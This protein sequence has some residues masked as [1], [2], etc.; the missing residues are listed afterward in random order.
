MAL[1][2]SA[3]VIGLKSSNSASLTLSFKAP[4]L[5]INPTPLL[6]Q[7]FHELKMAESVVSAEPDEP[8][9]PIYGTSI[10]LPASGSYRYTV[11][12]LGTE[13]YSNIRPLPAAK[14][15]EGLSAGYDQ[16]IYA[17]YQPKPLVQAAEIAVLRDF[18]ILQLSFSPLSWDSATG[19]LEVIR[20]FELDIE[21]T[22]ERTAS[23][24]EEYSTYSPAFRKIYEANLLNFGD[25]RHLNLDNGY[26]RILLLHSSSV[27]ATTLVIINTFVKWKVQKGYEVM[28][29][30]TQTAGSSNT[31][32]KNYIQQQYN[33][34]NT[35]P[36][37]VIIVGD[38]PQ[39]PTFKETLSGYNGDGDYPYTYLAGDDQLGD[40]FIGRVSANNANQLS[41]VLRK[42]YL[43]ERDLDISGENGNWMDKILLVGDQSSSGISCI[44]NCKH[45]KNMAE[46]AYDGYSFTEV[47]SSPFASAINDGINSGVAFFS[48]RGWLGMSGW[49]PGNALNNG[50]KLPHVVTLTCST[51]NFDGSGEGTTEALIR[52]G[53]DAA[54][55][56]AVT[57]IGMAT[58]GTHTMFNNVL[59]SGI[60]AGIFSYGMRSMGEALLNGKLFLRQ[61][62]GASHTN[63]TNYM[64]HWANLMGD[65]T[66]EVF[67]GKPKA[68]VI[69]SPTQVTEGSSL[70]SL[71]VTDQSGAPVPFVS[72]TAYN[73]QQNQLLAKG[74]TDEF[75]NIQF[76]IGGGIN[77]TVLLTA[78]RHDYKPAQK[79]LL[80][81]DGG[82][83]YADKS[84]F[85]NGQNGSI[86]NGDS[87]PTASERVAVKLKLKNTTEETISG[88]TATLSCS[89]S[90]VELLTSSLT[91]PN[92]SSYQSTEANQF[93]LFDIAENVPANYDVTIMALV[94][95]GG[96]SWE[97][98]V[99]IRVYNADI[100]VDSVIISA[101]G[102]AFLDPAE[103]GNMVV[104]V[105]NRSIALASGLQ[106]ELISHN[107]MIQV[108]SGECLLGSIPAGAFA[109][110]VGGFTVQANSALVPG[111]QIPF[112]LRLTNEDGFR[113]DAPFSLTVGKVNQNTPLGPDSY[114]YF[115]YDETD[116]SF[117]DCP[118]YEWIE[119][120][121]AL[122]GGGTSV[123]NQLL[124]TVNLPFPFT[125]YGKVYEQITLCTHGYIAMGVSDYPEY[126]N[127]PIPGGMGP[128][129][130]IAAFW[131]N[132]VYSGDAGIFYKYDTQENIFIVEYYKMRSGYNS[133]SL[134]TFQVIF[135]DEQFYSTGLG[136]GMIKIQ[137][138]DFNN[139]D[140]GYSNTQHGNY[141]TIGIKDH[142]NSRGLQYTYNNVYPP[143]AAPLGNNKAIL[144]TTIP[145][146]YESPYL[147][148]RDYIVSD[149]AGTG[150]AQP[151]QS[152]ELGIVLTNLGLTT[153]EE[154]S[155]E[156]SLN[157]PYATLST[158]QSEYPPIAC[159]EERA[160]TN[161]IILNINN[162]CPDGAILSLQATAYCG[163]S[164]WS[165]PV[166]VQVRKPQLQLLAA[167]ISDVLGNG[168]GSAD[169]GETIEL[170]LNLKNNSPLDAHDISCS[171]STISPY[172][173]INAQTEI[174]PLIPA[175][176]I[177]QAVY[178]LHLSEDVPLGNNVT[179]YF[180]YMGAQVT[181]ETATVSVSVGTT[182]MSEDFEEHNGNFIPSP[183]S[184]GWAWGTSTTAGAHS[185]NKVW[186]TVLNGQYSSNAHYSLITPQVFVGQNFMLEFW[187]RYE[188]EMTY[189]GACVQINTG[190]ATWNTLI[191]EG[192]Y[193]TSYV[194]SLS[195]PGYTGNSGGWLPARFSLSQY[196]NQLV[197]FRFL[198]RSDTSVQNNGWYIDDVRT[199]GYLELVGK[200]SGN[201]LSLDPEINYNSVLVS[202][203]NNVTASVSDQGEYVLYL[204]LGEHEVKA[205]SDGY[206]A[207]TPLQAD[208][209]M[210]SLFYEHDFDLQLLNYIEH[211]SHALNNGLLELFWTDVSDDDMAVSS[212]SVFRKFGAGAYEEIDVGG[213]VH[214]EEQLTVSGPYYYY[215]VANYVG[216][217]S[218]KSNTIHFVYDSLDSCDETQSPFITELY[219]NYPNPF[220]PQTTIS[221]SLRQDGKVSISLYNIKGQK[222]ATLVD[223]N[224]PKGKHSIVWQGRDQRGTPVS[225]GVYLLRMQSAD[226]VLSR[227]ISLIK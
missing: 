58:T 164:E 192:G 71:R 123:G 154:A 184:G 50:V 44:Y 128:A 177:A 75:G 37:F 142:T 111:M 68:L 51:G 212:Y 117:N 193:P 124:A 200:V 183:T 43:T 127:T 104:R 82:M 17:Q 32:I 10:I 214:F 224:L 34:L 89:D 144:I 99:P 6:G 121:P 171:F 195:G 137:Y 221:F 38:T 169:P 42:V 120:N 31:A 2:L 49:S 19:E 60:F 95:A 96:Q 91:F 207:S 93:F 191:P 59:N 141:A 26:G 213:F 189:D 41:T 39:I 132:L 24:M 202:N 65:P 48:Y 225:S 187:H 145:V 47:Y 66:V 153:A 94:S 55:R 170:I 217:T 63:Q 83:V 13:S 138:K 30:N 185:G 54:P 151:G 197:K 203:Q 36:D 103:T 159:G 156:V 223:E 160:N 5:E 23:D 27:D 77:S 204:P 155:I 181:P 100:Q 20:E 161:P 107:E 102:D 227:K 118:S 194:N 139:I 218:R 140:T 215:V 179:F 178:Q 168:N 126:R 143:A 64:A 222:V 134:E 110:T 14:V 8:G 216:G 80:A 125:F 129:P 163:S 147:F 173:T 135:Y 152:V 109:N 40:V 105:E 130:M 18:R 226:G 46:Q 4:A 188:T 176:G 149:N 133:S 52:L 113:Q 115:I 219:P 33:N 16:S 11:R 106:A 81:G 78:A 72:M 86:G 190:G 9:L 90:Y 122:G 88:I 157:S 166:N 210:Q 101:G 7:Q 162:N 70:I 211:L 182:G 220:N 76:F 108:Q 148:Y 119:I 21:F 199:S 73:A 201:I 198:F 84:I 180:T 87:F 74:I 53:T 98:P 61:V 174:I 25:Y 56:G 12:P 85:E 208:I 167:N 158:F 175:E 29:A 45:V 114:G 165:F 186:G 67:V 116:T 28:A 79:Q 57:A 136:D 150:V 22:N 1:S 131:D 92:A 205:H 172:V 35:R 62:Y 206:L 3:N 196:S 15:E 69:E 146:L 209:S 97:V 112:T